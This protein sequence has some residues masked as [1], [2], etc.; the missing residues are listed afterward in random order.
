MPWRRRKSWPASNGSK[1]CAAHGTR[2]ADAALQFS[3]RPSRCLQHR[4]GGN[5]GSGSSPEYRLAVAQDSSK[6]VVRSQGGRTARVPCSGPGL[7]HDTADRR[8]ST[9]LAH[10]PRRLF[11]A[12]ARARRDLSRLFNPED[13]APHLATHAA[14][15]Q[16][17]WC[18]PHPRRPRRPAC[19]ILRTRPHSSPAWSA[20]PSLHAPDAETN[21]ARLAADPLLV[22]LRPM[23]QD[24]DDDDWLAAREPAPAFD[25]MIAHQLQVSMRC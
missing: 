13:Q 8:A 25:A 21:I 9:F 2:L 23:V 14:L 4:A 1:R 17:S 3:A 10:R 12:D 19:S 16:P 15:Q 5:V 22:G 24:I 7:S 18:R 11:V 20:G 6:S